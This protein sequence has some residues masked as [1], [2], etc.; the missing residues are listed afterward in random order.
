MPAA[1]RDEMREL[2]TEHRRTAR[3]VLFDVLENLIH[4]EL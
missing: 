3:M 1:L 2:A 4:C